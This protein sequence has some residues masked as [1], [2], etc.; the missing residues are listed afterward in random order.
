MM[1]M[2]E[3]IAALTEALE[4]WIRQVVS[5][6]GARG[7]VVGLSGGIDS[8]AAAALAVRALGVENVLGLVMPCDSL[9]EDTE[10]GIRI[11]RHLSIPHKV[12]KLDDLLNLFLLTADLGNATRLEKANVKARLRMTML[13]AHSRHRL[14]LGT[15]NYSEILVGYW[16]KWGDGASDMLP[17]GR[18][19]KDEVYRLSRYMG[20]PKWVL[21]RTPSAGLWAGQ[22]DEEEM[23]VTYSAIRSYFQG[24]DV[25][26]KV[27]GR[28]EEMVRLTEHKRKPIVYFDARQW[29]NEKSPDGEK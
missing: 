3:E 14:V 1:K 17:L 27:A 8:A 16:T 29:L 22:S 7:V 9:P 2:N 21:D 25:S 13:Y 20:L 19:Y 10:D 6:A 11:A 23:G 24:E 15:S 5:G 26:G 12:L 18:L 28:I 4:E